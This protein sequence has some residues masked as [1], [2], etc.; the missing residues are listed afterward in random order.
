MHGKIL[1]MPSMCRDLYNY[2]HIYKYTNHILDGEVRV[3]A[4]VCFF[5][6]KYCTDM[7]H[8]TIV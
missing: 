7:Q 1:P 8:G 2:Q 4:D 6:H 5:F 3:K